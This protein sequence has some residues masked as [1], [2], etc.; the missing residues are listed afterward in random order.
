M[1]QFGVVFLYIYTFLYSITYLSII[2]FIFLFRRL[3]WIVVYF[4]FIFILVYSMFLGSWVPH[5]T[6]FDHADRKLFEMNVSSKKKLSFLFDSEWME[7]IDIRIASKNDTM[8]M[9]HLSISTIMGNLLH[10]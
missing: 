7:L 4:I 6:W 5:K 9:K 3:V 2:L 8:K 10:L 1:K